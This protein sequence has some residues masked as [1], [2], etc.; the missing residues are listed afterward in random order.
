MMQARESDRGVRRKK[1]GRLWQIG[2]PAEVAWIQRGR[3]GG[4]ETTSAIPP[5]FA[6]YATLTLPVD[7]CGNDEHRHERA[8]LEVL[9]DQTDEQSWWLGYLETGASEVVFPD[10][11]R[12]KLYWDWS[13]VLVNAGADQAAAWGQEGQDQQLWNWALPALMFPQDRSWLVSTLWDDEWSS[14]GGSRALI[15]EL[16]RH[17]L[18]GRS[19]RRLGR[20]DRATPLGGERD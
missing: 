14:I 19:T 15:A 18:L 8:V 2:G 3:T 6:D 16:E 1:D 11:P 9:R 20:S 7:F 10:A 17:P 13:Y 12:V 5:V 4:R